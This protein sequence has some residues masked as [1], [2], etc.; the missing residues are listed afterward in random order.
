MIPK[1]SMLRNELITVRGL[2]GASLIAVGFILNGT[3]LQAQTLKSESISRNEMIG[4]R[5]EILGDCTV[6]VSTDGGAFIPAPDG[7]YEPGVDGEPLTVRNGIA[8]RP[9]CTAERGTGSKG[10]FAVGGFSPA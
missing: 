9:P 10:G 7:V 5:L 2:V 1:V 8:V 3:Q 6:V 4:A